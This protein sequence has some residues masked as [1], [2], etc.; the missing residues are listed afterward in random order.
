MEQSQEKKVTF[1]LEPDIKYFN[2]N[3]RVYHSSSANVSHHHN[4][5]HNNLNNKFDD[6][7]I[8][9][10]L[11]GS[12]EQMQTNNEIIKFVKKNKTK[13]IFYSLSGAI[14][15]LTLSYLFNEKI[16]K[17]KV[18]Y[19]KIFIAVILSVVISKFLIN[20]LVVS[21]PASAPR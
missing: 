10:A 3:D 20:K 19:M 21:T 7:Y 5:N 8:K 16:L 18:K 15:I 1:N 17:K 11:R 6:K 4:R 14:S 9:S 12:N 13:I 2:E